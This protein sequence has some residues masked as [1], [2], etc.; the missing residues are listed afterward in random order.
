VEHTFQD[1]F[2]V[3]LDDYLGDPT[4]VIPS[5]V[6]GGT[7]PDDDV[8]SVLSATVG[9][10]NGRVPPISPQSRAPNRGVNNGGAPRQPSIARPPGNS[11]GATLPERTRR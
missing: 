4:L 5:R 11:N 6:A 10:P 7:K 9:M 8:P 1:R 3:A 2:Q